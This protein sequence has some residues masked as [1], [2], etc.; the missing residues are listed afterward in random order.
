ME[1]RI[2][3]IWE[4]EKNGKRYWVLSINGEKYSVWDEKY[5]NGLSE[6][7]SVDYNWKKSGDF[8]KITDIRK[9]DV[10]PIYSKNEQIIRM[11]CI[12]SAAVLVSDFDADPDEKG[13]VALGIARKFEQYVIEGNED[14]KENP[15][16]EE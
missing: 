3:K 6:G 10:Q 8:R 11:S 14:K 4:N 13:E 12:K 5:M 1:G 9:L 15:K 7:S 16:Q 2:D